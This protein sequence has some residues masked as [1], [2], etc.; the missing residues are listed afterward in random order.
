MG[1]SKDGRQRPRSSSGKMTPTKIALVRAARRHAR[2]AL[3]IL[4]EGFG[5]LF[6]TRILALVGLYVMLAL[7]LNIVVG[8]AGLLDL[9]YIAFYAIGAYSGVIVG[10]VRRSRRFPCARAVHVL[11]DDP[12]RRGVRGAARVSRSARRSCDCAATT[13]PSSRSASARSS[14]SSSTTTRS[15]SPTVPRACPRAGE[16]LPKPLGLEWLQNNAYFTIP[17][18]GANGFNFMF[19]S[20]LYW[21]Y[22]IVLLCCSTDLRGQPA[23]QLAPRPLVGRDARGRGRG[24]V[25]GRQHHAAPSCGRSRSARSGAASPA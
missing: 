20:N 16:F 3:P 23:R 21:Y 1:G 6:M 9:G 19:S 25:D 22:I 5:M 17:G 14:A 10:V 12:G 15:A 18:L 2:S 11:P 24:G 13:S 4:F 8:Y 7:G